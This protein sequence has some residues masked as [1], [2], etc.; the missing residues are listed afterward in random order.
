[1]TRLQRLVFLVAV[2]LIFAPLAGAQDESGG[3]PLVL[4]DFDLSGSAT[5]GY[6]F[7][8]VKGYTPQF[9]EMF[10]LRGGF[11]LLDLNLYGESQEG[12]NPFADSFS[13]QTTSLGGDPYPT[14]Q[15]TISKKKVY[16]FRV[17]WRQSYYYW[18]QNDNVALQIG[19][20]HV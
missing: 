1:M 16:D 4:G 7:D 13:L 6:R 18:N 15:F 20:A 10:N 14:A 2:L 17:N 5:G 8:T 19:R 3:T 9:R 11:R 12:K